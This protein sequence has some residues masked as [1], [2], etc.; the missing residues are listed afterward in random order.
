MRYSK[1]KNLTFSNTLYVQFLIYKVKSAT[2]NGKKALVQV[3]YIKL[4]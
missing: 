4:L 2:V 1:H 3:R